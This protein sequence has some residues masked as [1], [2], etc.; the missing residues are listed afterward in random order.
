MHGHHPVPRL[1]HGRVDERLVWILVVAQ[2]KRVKRARVCLCQ[3][4]AR[5][6]RIFDSAH[7][8][9]LLH[10]CQ[11]WLRLMRRCG[12]LHSRERTARTNLAHAF[13]TIYRAWL[14]VVVR[15]MCTTARRHDDAQDIL[16]KGENT[17]SD[18][19]PAWIDQWIDMQSKERVYDGAAVSVMRTAA[20][21]S[22][23]MRR[24]MLEFP[25]YCVI[26]FPDKQTTTFGIVM[27]V[28]MI[29][30]DK[31]PKGMSKRKL[32]L[33]HV[34][35]P[36]HIAGAT[37]PHERETSYVFPEGVD[38]IA[39]SPQFTPDAMRALIAPVGSA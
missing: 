22:A 35:S 8:F 3:D 37:T 27:G 25:P 7:Q 33:R 15:D 17:M 1:V 30:L 28:T 39:Y 4:R 19:R 16:L 5:P 20:N 21:S 12:Y 38:V 26:R 18:Q 23:D 36:L 29:D 2:D 24:V 31:P 13:L 14:S 34:P 10:E 9:A 11:L 32:A 6:P